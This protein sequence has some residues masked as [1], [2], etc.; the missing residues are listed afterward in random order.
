M[1]SAI[2]DHTFHVIEDAFAVLKS[3]GVF[4]TKKVFRRGDRFYAAWG[5]GFIRLGAQ[6]ATSAPKV[7]LEHLELPA[8]VIVGRDAARNPTYAGQ[9]ALREAA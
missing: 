6:D 7:A 1:S 5:A 9:R 2:N 8:T 3:G 4:Y